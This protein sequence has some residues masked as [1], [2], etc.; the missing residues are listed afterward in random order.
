[1]GKKF[2]K[3]DESNK[4]LNGAEFV[5]KRK[6]D[7]KFLAVKSSV[8]KGNELNT[9]NDAEKAYQGA[10]DAYNAAALK[11]AI[12]ASNPVMI[13]GQS[14]T[15]DAAAKVKIAELKKARDEAYVA[16]N[17][18]W[19]WVE[20]QDKAFK[21]ISNQDGQFE[22]MGLRKRTYTLVE[23]KAPAGFA[24]ISDIDF[25]VGP[26]TASTGNI[27]YQPEGATNDATKV[28][29]RKVSIPQTGGI[30]TAIFV[31]IGLTLMGAAAYTL[32]KRERQLVR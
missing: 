8:N 13:G 18:E 5:V 10:V 27:K 12:S 16:V 23:T 7:G 17:M 6:L 29:N 2:V 19:E 25:E 32:T 15:D 1:Y 9:Y 11:G 20:T 3:T 24:K 28:V 21:F 31:L 4:R 26:G 22:V 30:G 14:F